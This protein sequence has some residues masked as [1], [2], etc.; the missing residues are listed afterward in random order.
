VLYTLVTRY[1][2]GWRSVN[3]CA[4]DYYP[5]LTISAS[6]KMDI[7]TLPGLDTWI[8]LQTI[9]GKEALHKKVGTWISDEACLRQRSHEFA[10]L[11]QTLKTKPQVEQQL[12]TSFRDLA[13]LEPDLHAVVSEASDLE[14]EAFNELLFLQPWSTPLN[15]VP[16]LLF[17]WSL[18]RVY[19]LPGMAILTPILMLILPFFMVRFFFGIPITTDRYISLVSAMFT[20]QVTALFRDTPSPP[21]AAKFDI[22]QLVKGGFLIMTVAQSFLQPYW[23][24][25]HLSSIDRIIIQKAG[26]LRKFNAIYEEVRD[27]LTGHGYTL[28]PNP[29][30][31]VTTDDRQL[32]A[33]AHLHPTYLKYAHRRL[34]A[35]E[36]LVCLAR[37]SDLVPVAWS[38]ST[39]AP[40][41]DL[42]ASFDYHVS[43]DTRVPFDLCL[44]ARSQHALLTGPNRGGK[45]TTLRAIAAACVL[46][47]TYGCAPGLR[48]RMTPFHTLY[49]CLTPEDL[50]GK[51]SRFER[52]IEFTASSLAAPPTKRTLVLLDELYHSTNPPDAERACGLY[53]QQLWKRPQTLSIISTHLFDFVKQAPQTIQR[54]CCPASLRADGSVHYTYRL[55]QGLS[56]VSSVGELLKEN[57]LH[58]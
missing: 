36:V 48:A 30:G 29:F 34:G 54:L 11:Q 13:A 33:L 23:T 14:K 41:L 24:F 5:S 52:E 17:L 16:C 56:T 53:T 38:S 22:F 7:R 18:L 9:A 6:N 57:G 10:I 47:H 58:V 12:R 49:V 46:A 20:G 4:C 50:P 15:F 27:I 44:D 51:K 37:R 1:F 45:S 26:A 25:K 8:G 42:Q 32:V 43:E 31:Q 35:L 55:E 28:S 2:R 21:V 3:F 19:I 40:L 39:A